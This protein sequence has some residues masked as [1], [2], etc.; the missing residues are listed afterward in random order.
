MC[1]S[2]VYLPEWLG[3]VGLDT[4]QI[5]LVLAS[6]SWLKVPITL[7]AGNV[8]DQIGR[9]KK[10]LLVCAGLMA[11]VLPALFFVRGYFWI[12][13]IWACAGALVSTCVP[14]TDSISVTAVRREGAQYGRI[15]MWGSI[16]F[17]IASVSCGWLI[18]YWDVDTTAIWLL[19]LGGVTLLL[20]VM[21]LPDYK[22]KPPVGRG[23][24]LLPV[25][26]LPGFAL[27]LFVAATL[28]ASH[29]ALYSLSTV[30]WS[31]LGIP[32]STI[33]LLWAT[34]VVAEVGIFFIS[35]RVQSLLGPWR[36]FAIAGL[37]G[38]LRWS[39][40]ALVADVSLL[41]AIQ[42]LH[43]IT[44]TFTQ[45]AVVG[46]IARRVPE[47]LTSSAQTV[48]DSCAIGIVFGVA[49]YV[50]G[51]L[52]RTDI[53]LS[54]WAMAGMSAVAASI[55]VVVILRQQENSTAECSPP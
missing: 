36:L 43:A 2:V 41:F 8:A 46:Y 54:F 37:T 33:G 47:E 13:V 9:R 14:L 40:T 55:A 17:L 44:F 30:H 35:T 52:A 22:T 42:L 5:G 31:S 3:R 4:G 6:A 23:F 18:S 26:K 1:L 29:A 53:A 38:V 49:L 28:M 25:L 10:V 21:R 11:C 50:S 39:L 48:Y 45:L 12:C 51:L 20:A 19:M 27:F 15:R 34:G 32:L 24:T 7:I 16:S